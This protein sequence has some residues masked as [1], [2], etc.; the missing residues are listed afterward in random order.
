MW[1]KWDVFTAS[2]LSSLAMPANRGNHDTC[3][4]ERRKLADFP[5]QN[6]SGP[7][8]NLVHANDAP[9]GGG[10]RQQPQV[11]FDRK[12]LQTILNVYGRKVAEGEWRDYALDFLKDRALFSIYRHHSERPIYVVEKNPKLANKQGQY[13]VINQDGRILKRGQVLETVLRILDPQLSVV[14]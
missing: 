9:A 5:S 6:R 1:P 3:V 8:P 13:L 12:E 10:G 2:G 7:S 4:T 11:G 14:R